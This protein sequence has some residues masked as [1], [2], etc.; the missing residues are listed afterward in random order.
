[1]SLQWGI[2]ALVGF[3]MLEVAAWYFYR[4][5]NNNTGDY[6]TPALMFV[7]F[8]ANVRKTA[9]RVLV[10]LVSMGFGVVKWT[11][12]TTR[13]KIGLLAVFYMFFSFLVQVIKEISDIS[14]KEE[15]SQFVVLFVIIP[16]SILDATFY[17]WIILSL[18]RTMQQLTLR[19]QILKLQMYKIFFSV[20][21]IAGLL[22]GAMI[23]YG[24]YL[25]YI[26][27]ERV[28]WQ[29]EWIVDTAFWESLFWGI[30]T[31]IAI[32]WRPRANNTRYGY[33]EFFTQEN[34]DG[35]DRKEDSDGQIP[36][37]TITVAGTEITQRRKGK[38]DSPNT[39]KQK[40]EN[41]REKN[42]KASMANLGDFEKDIISIE[43]P[44]DDENDVT[45]ETQIRKMD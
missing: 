1:M 15:V 11:L 35:N 27:K 28:A 17:Y 40:Y 12:G 44:S 36:L 21:V 43:L 9:S 31:V 32:L 30:T 2:L 45:I 29:H 22:S 25:N 7:V 4:L 16:A 13:I 26:A 8:L 14:Q 42:I 20:L 18:I 33:G 23:L 38:P 39:N 19:R 41:E 6:S 10:L 37:E 5:G 24:G 34:E 3:G